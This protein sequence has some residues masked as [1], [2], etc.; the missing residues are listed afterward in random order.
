[1]KRIVQMAIIGALAASA[2]PAGDLGDLVFGKDTPDL[3][4]AEIAYEYIQRDFDA[5]TFEADAYYLRAYTDVGPLASLDF[6]VGGLDYGGDIGIFGGVGLRYLVYDADQWRVGA[7]AQIRYAP[8]FEGE[9]DGRAVEADIIEGDIGLPVALKLKTDQVVV[10][11]YAGPLFSMLRVGGDAADG[12]SLD[13]DANTFG[14]LFG[15]QLLFP[16]G[17]G[18]R[19]EGRYL[20]DVSFSAA[21]SIAF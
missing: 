5:G 20:D 4:R 2:A 10:S 19:L 12:E 15:V 16:G 6:T 8:E 7:A 13:E 11:P 21:A 14:G 1:M 17:N 18:I 3:G 9:F